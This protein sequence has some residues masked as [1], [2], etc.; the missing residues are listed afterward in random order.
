M[1]ADL[2]KKET[3]R[4]DLGALNSHTLKIF[5]KT[6]PQLQQKAYQAFDLQ[7]EIQLHIEVGFHG[8]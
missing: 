8:R 4:L 3:I 5:D 2:K 6:L 7:M 1:L